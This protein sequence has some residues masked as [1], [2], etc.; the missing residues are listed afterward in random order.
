M[1]V[2]R[3]AA[4]FDELVG[5]TLV[6]ASEPAR[7]RVLF[8]FFFCRRDATFKSLAIDDAR[9]SMNVCSLLACRCHFDYHYDRCFTKSSFLLFLESSDAE[10]IISDTR[11]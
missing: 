10:Y 7:H 6:A 2:R 1:P 5:L 9:L 4:L 8:R 3:R 11:R